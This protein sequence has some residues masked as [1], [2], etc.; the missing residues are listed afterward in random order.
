MRQWDDT[1]PAMRQEARHGDRVVTCFVKRWHSLHALLTQAV[2]RNADGVALVCDEQRMTYRKLQHA[3]QAVAGALR[4][5]GVG[6]GDRVALLL[7]NRP[8]PINQTRAR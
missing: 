8:E 4:E 2:E 7:G 5:H 6:A 1:W 3:S